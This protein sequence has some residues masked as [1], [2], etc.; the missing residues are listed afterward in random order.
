MEGFLT[1]S[2]FNGRMFGWQ[3]IVLEG[4]NIRYWDMGLTWRNLEGLRPSLFTTWFLLYLLTLLRDTQELVFAFLD[5]QSL[6]LSRPRRKK[7][8]MM[9][10]RARWTTL[11]DSRMQGKLSL[12]RKVTISK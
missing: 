6:A 7:D 9:I 12:D 1:K 11:L 5:R 3:I 2:I 4:A 10:E 8:L